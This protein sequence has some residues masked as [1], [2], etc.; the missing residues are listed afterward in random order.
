VTRATSPEVVEHQG[1]RA[2]I[3]SRLLAAIVDVLAVILISVLLLVVGGA[4]R[5]LWKGSFEVLTPP[6]PTREILAGLIFLAYFGYGWGLNGRT[7]GKIALGLRA[8]G[9]DGSD[10]PT[11][12]GF[13]RAAL[14]ILLIPGFLWILVSRRNA[15][16]QDLVLRTA[17]IHDWGRGTPG[18]PGPT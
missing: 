4:V 11:W 9:A 8:V 5:A 3:A 13:A 7:L 17:V 16:V 10:L 18:H 15:S 12:R 14:Y 1:R 6:S 2:G